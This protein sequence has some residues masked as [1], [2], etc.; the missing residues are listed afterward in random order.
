MDPSDKPFICYRGQG[1]I[2]FVPRNAA[3]WRALVVW[4]A[5]HGVAVVLFVAAISRAGGAPWMVAAVVGGF[6]AFCVAWGVLGY[7]WVSV[8]SEER[9]LAELIAERRRRRES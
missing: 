9:D 4:L 6:I 1:R 2:R 3:G 8:R 7:R 5:I